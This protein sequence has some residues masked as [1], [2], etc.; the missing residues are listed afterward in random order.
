M[1]G[2]LSGYGGCVSLVFFDLIGE[3][4]V[5]GLF[6]QVIIV[7]NWVERRLVFIY[8]FGYEKNVFQVLVMLYC[9]N[10]IIVICVVDGQVC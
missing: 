5:F 2:E 9:D 3:F 10:C 8:N 4:L 6:D 7:W 1:Y